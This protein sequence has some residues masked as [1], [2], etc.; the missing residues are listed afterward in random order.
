MM[1]MTE[2][3]QSNV[4]VAVV[5]QGRGALQG[6]AMGNS[7]VP[8]RVKSKSAST[9]FSTWPDRLGTDRAAC[10]VA[11]CSVFALDETLDPGHRSGGFGYKLNLPM[12]VAVRVRGRTMGG[13]VPIRP[14]SSRTFQVQGVLIRGSQP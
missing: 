10:V 6:A 5:H 2:T 12:E 8:F 4:G 11:A 14:H 1:L 13:E 3:P 7:P 9:V